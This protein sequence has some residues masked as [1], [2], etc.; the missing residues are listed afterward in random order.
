MACYSQV[1]K[2]HIHKV[3]CSTSINC[4][5]THVWRA[6]DCRR[7]QSVKF[8]MH[9]PHSGSLPY[10]LRAELGVKPLPCYL[11]IWVIRGNISCM[12]L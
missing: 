1:L 3:Q 7:L 12:L 11:L 5:Q 9:E 2:P 10:A 8:W 6:M 4:F